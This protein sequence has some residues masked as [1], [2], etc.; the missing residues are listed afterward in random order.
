MKFMVYLILSLFAQQR[1]C[2][3]ISNYDSNKDLN[4]VYFHNVEKVLSYPGNPI[5]T[6]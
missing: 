5:F 3:S 2:F 4:V 1:I 6:Y